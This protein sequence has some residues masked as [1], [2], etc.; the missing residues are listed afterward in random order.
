MQGMDYWVASEVGRLKQVILHRPGL[1]MSRLT[2]GNKDD[3]LFDDL[4]WLDNAQAEHDAFAGVLRDAGAEVLYLQNLLT[5]TLG[6]PEAKEHVLSRVVDERIFGPE[7]VEALRSYTDQLPQEAL[8]EFLVG[9]MTKREWLDRLP[10]PN[11]MDTKFMGLDDFMLNPLPNHLFT[12]DTSCWVY[13]G[14]AI[15]SMSKPARQRETIT[16]EAVYRWHPLFADA[17][18]RRWGEGVI[19]GRSTVEGGDVLVIGNGA[20]LVGLSE[21]TAAMGAERMARRLFK[22]GSA[23]MVVCVHLPKERAQMH[24]DTVMT[25]LDPESFVRYPLFGDRATWVLRPGAGDSIDI[26]TH[27]PEDFRQV[28]ATALGVPSVRLLVPPYDGLTAEREQWNDA[29]NVLAVA[30]GVVVGYDRN[31]RTSDFLRSHGIEVLEVPGAEL[32]RGRGGPRCMSCPT[33]RAE[34]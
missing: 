4:L 27:G 5:E 15:N 16:Y 31:K 32:G 28:L 17:G 6:V 11:S 34:V 10:E 21:R 19:E 18:F 14:V 29:C 12:R 33:I 22:A 24:L 3:L 2:P 13:D 20:V 1:E 26:E 25:M 9:G 7:G 8:A 23:Q 30:P